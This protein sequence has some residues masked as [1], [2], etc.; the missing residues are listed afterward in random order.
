MNRPREAARL[1][2]L[3]E[4][5]DPNIWL[6]V[7]RAAR[8]ELAMAIRGEPFIIEVN[9]R[10]RCHIRFGITP[11]GRVLCPLSGNDPT[12]LH[13]EGPPEAVAGFVLGHSSLTDA[14][15]DE[16]LTIRSGVAT[17]RLDELHNVVAARLRTLLTDRAVI[18]PVWAL[19]WRL[20]RAT[21]TPVEW[22]AA[23]V[24]KVAP[25]VAASMVAIAGATPGVNVDTI[26]APRPIV[27]DA[28]E[29]AS[30]APAPRLPAP[31]GQ[32]RPNSTV[33]TI[34]APPR[35]PVDRDAVR[36]DRRAEAELGGPS[37]R[38]ATVPVWGQMECDGA[39]HRELICDAAER[40]PTAP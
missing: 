36:V 29:M 18:V 4:Q 19:L 24:A 17:S 31:V 13:I 25:V 9:A 6:D 40:L 26:A 30:P 21:T 22:T 32:P 27:A 33:R 12:D 8:D 1:L 14:L 15:A 20:R 34:V 3:C 2:E 7:L 38:T 5:A 16:L 28:A 39:W 37:E 23:A 10:R 35:P 11:L